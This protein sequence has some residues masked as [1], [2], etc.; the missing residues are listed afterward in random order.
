VLLADFVDIIQQLTGQKAKLVP[1]AM[2]S[3]DIPYTFADI[4][5]ARHLL[6]YEPKTS[7]QAGV[8]RFWQWYQHAVLGKGES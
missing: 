4:Q 7:V 1:A 8:E 5:K 2:E 6:G 3:A